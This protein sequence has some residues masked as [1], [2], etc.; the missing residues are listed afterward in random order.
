M[1]RTLVFH[2]GDPKNGSSS[3][4]QALQAR[5]CQCDGVSIVPQ[6]E[7]NASMMANA[8]NPKKTKPLKYRRSIDAKKSWLKK[9]DGD[10]GIISAEFFSAV[11]PL[12]MQKTLREE[13]PEHA[14][15][16]RIIAYVRPHASRAVSSYAQRV[17]T[18]V[19]TRSFKSFISDRERHSKL[20]YARRFTAW[21]E[22]FGDRF[23]LRPF[24]RDE[25]AGRDVVQDF[26]QTV[27]GERPFTLTPQPRSNESL[28]LEEIA[29]MRIVQAVMNE[30]DVPAFLRLS[31]GGAIGRG[32][33]AQKGR[34]KN[35]L[36]L[37]RGAAE[38]LLG[39]YRKD[40]EKLDKRFFSST[41]ML[42]ALEEAL[43]EALPE[44]QSLEPEDY[45]DAAA[46]KK[47]KQLSE[48]IAKLVNE[49][50]HAWRQ[51]YQARIGQRPQLKQDMGRRRNA[52][53]VWTA[54][55]KICPLL[56]SGSASA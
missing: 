9:N 19:D 27:L 3:I 2:I 5:A 31:L 38:I 42:Q 15:A 30:H 29:G 13:F 17:K 14:D 7:L 52:K 20:T 36:A 51:Q 1:I 33:A 44:P 22:V 43:E 46:R 40:A 12:V 50:P 54:L 45:L 16:A 18:G 8:L 10:L 28:T 56:A 25:M 35:R 48:R 24:I 32:L 49:R 41:P 6:E 53:G 21:S 26:F 55:D 34:T 37:D 23:V 4:Q 47:L 39:A 11:P